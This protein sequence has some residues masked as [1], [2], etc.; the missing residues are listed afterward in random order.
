MTSKKTI[1]ALVPNFNHASFLEQALKAL[2]SQSRRPDQVIIVDDASTDESLKVINKFSHEIGFRLIRNETNRGPVESLMRALHAA[3]TDYVFSGAADDMVLP[4]F[5]E[6]C[7]NALDKFPKA[8]ICTTHPAFI[9]EPAGRLDLNETTPKFSKEPCYLSPTEVEKSVHPG[10][11]WIPGHA[12]LVDRLEFLRVVEDTQDLKW[13]WDWFGMHIVALRSG[14]C[15]VPKALSAFR[16]SAS[17]YSSNSE[18]K[19]QETANILWSMANIINQKRFDDV[20]PAILRSKLLDFFPRFRLKIR[21][22]ITPWGDHDNGKYRFGKSLLHSLKQ[23]FIEELLSIVQFV[24]SFERPNPPYQLLY[25]G[26]R[27]LKW[28]LQPRLSRGKNGE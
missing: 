9:R 26:L 6:E 12:S 24:K 14:L 11:L 4:G 18:I 10:G 28:L 8:R 2:F 3:N 5:F 17:S 7:M 27:K 23:G 13:H 19:L 16:V 1:A 22:M 20:R 15:Y 21:D 25:R